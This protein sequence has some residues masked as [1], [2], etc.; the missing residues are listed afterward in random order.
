MRVKA[1][2]PASSAVLG[3][4]LPARPEAISCDVLVVG[5][6]TGGVAAALAAARGGHSVC[7][8]EE[9][10]WIGGQMTAQG[11]SAFDENKYIE[12]T[13]GTPSYHRLRNGV[14]QYYGQHYNLSTQGADEKFF[15]PGHCWVSALCFEPEAALEV[16]RSMLQPYLT[17]A[18][19]GVPLFR[20]FLR[21]KAVSAQTSG[22][23]I[24]SV[25]TYGFESRRWI[26]F[27][28]RCVLDATDLGELVPL[29]G[30]EYVTG[31][32]P[33]SLTGEPHARDDA[34][35][36]NDNQSFTYTFVLA[37]DPGHIHV[38]AKP[39]EYEAHRR[40]QPYA[41]T[42]DYGKGKRLTYRMLDKAPQTPGAF[43]TYRRLIAVDNF[44]GPQVPREVSMINWPGNDY[45]GPGLLSNDPEQQA[46]ALREAKATSMGFAY[47]LQTEV[48]RD[49]G[50][51]GYPD[52]EL[53]TSELGSSDGLSQYPY[54]R[55][56]RRIRALKTIREQEISALYQKAARAELFPDSVGIGL[57]PI[58]IHSCSRQDFTSP[59][60]PFQIPIGAL[61]PQRIENLLAA[62]KDI[63]TTHI[64]NGAYRLHPVE[65]AIGE[66]AGTLASFALDHDVAPAKI[67]RDSSL[68]E[69][70][71]L[72]LLD[73]GA[74]LYWFDDL[75]IGD[76][77]FRAAQFLAVHGIFGSNESDLHFAPNRPL[78]RSEAVGALARVV[79]SATSLASGGAS[80]AALTA[81]QS[82]TEQG[83]LP[84]SF[85]NPGQLDSNLVWSDLDLARRKTGVQAPPDRAESNPVT[86]A[87]FAI[88]LERVYRAVTSDK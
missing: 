67:A 4:D 39:P 20:V 9:T 70:L 80:R 68:T 41:L 73:A 78:T 85:S 36:P 28:P 30:A 11:V 37:R 31:A 1:D 74:P 72:K 76:P 7:L 25:L 59:S 38:L 77:S 33:R 34:G 27:H 3:L 63:G 81:L 43:W 64:T 15:N 87:Q 45:C 16:L 23:R 55:E 12:T 61:I 46:Q 48:P 83:Y 49:D 26:R 19:H 22:N 53:L 13:A 52:M 42:V 58:D 71:Q 75:E 62:S 17:R 21:T 29:V 51:K 14:R 82:L 2:Q 69:K 10:A 47:W 40:D 18:P 79:G 86:R 24:S 66:A 57:Y 44:V 65:W 84:A 6:S 5:A 8:T 60:K 35:D 32:E 56:S 50:G 54:I 88:W